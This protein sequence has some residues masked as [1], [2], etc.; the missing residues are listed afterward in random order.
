MATIRPLLP[1]SVSCALSKHMT[2]EPLV[3]VASAAA[4]LNV[5][6]KTVRR[7]VTA[8]ELECR[9]VGRQLRFEPAVLRD[10]SARPVQP[11]PSSATGFRAALAGLTYDAA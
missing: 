4:Y 3:D 2:D 6:V 9:R 8:G 7:L 1:S 5:S 11:V 10:Y